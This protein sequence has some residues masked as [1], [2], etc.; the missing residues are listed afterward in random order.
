MKFNDRGKVI[1]P[2]KLYRNTHKGKI[3]GVCAGLADFYDTD[4]HLVR[5]L[6][7]LAAIFFTK[8]TVCVYLIAGIVLPRRPGWSYL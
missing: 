2:E 1:S 6:A 5:I 3:M 7:I 8:L 4:R